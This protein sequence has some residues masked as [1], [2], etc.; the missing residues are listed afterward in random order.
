M[1]KTFFV[2]DIISITLTVLN[3]ILTVVFKYDVAS[4]LSSTENDNQLQ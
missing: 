1:K 4:L 3:F 2:L